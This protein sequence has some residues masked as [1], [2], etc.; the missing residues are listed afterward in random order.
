MDCDTGQLVVLYE[1]TILFKAA[2][3]KGD[4]RRMKQV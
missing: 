4:T 2:S 1:W 3:K